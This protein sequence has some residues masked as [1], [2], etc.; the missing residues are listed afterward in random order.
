MAEDWEDIREEGQ[1]AEDNAADET[2]PIDEGSAVP[3]G[4]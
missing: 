2:A 4:K 1:E 3:S